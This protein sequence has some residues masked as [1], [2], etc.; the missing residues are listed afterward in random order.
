MVHF[1][2]E[3]KT[4]SYSLLLITLFSAKMSAQHL[5]SIA[6]STINIE[7]VE[8]AYKDSGKGQVIICLH[9]VGHSSSDFKSLYSLPLDKYRV[10]AI[11]FPGHGRSGKP[12]QPVSATYFKSIVDSF[13]EKKSLK[14]VV[15]VGNS[16]GGAT[17]IRFASSNPNVKAIALANPGGIDKG[18]LFA[19]LFLNYM[20]SF[21]KKGERG[22]A[23]FAARFDKLY[24]SI[25]TTDAAN[26]RRQ[27]I[28][29]SAYQ[30]APLLVQ[31]WK[32]FSRKEEDLRPL[33]KNI[34]CPV[35]F[36]WAIKDKIVRFGRNKKAIAQFENAQLIKYDIGHTPYVECPETFLKDFNNFLDQLPH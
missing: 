32:S 17:A 20:V 21:F 34:H 25:L 5:P 3:I 27:E 22:D 9:A 36:T 24:H 29:N 31:A 6:D 4:A 35:L 11:D 16:I 14:D 12:L 30:I 23:K 15:I 26:E 18:G 33:I 19:P 7:N 28:I 13:I 2:S 10:I 1:R 8:I